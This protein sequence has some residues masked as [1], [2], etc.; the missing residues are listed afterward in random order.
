M[1]KAQPQIKGKLIKK[2]WHSIVAGKDF[3]SAD[4]GETL[5]ADPSSMMHRQLTVNLANLTGDIRQQGISLQFKVSEIRDGKGI[6]GVTGYEASASQLHRLVRRGVERLDDSIECM[7]SDGVTIKIKPF[8]VTKSAVSKS[9][10]R[11]M[12]AR[13]REALRAESAKTT[14]SDF[15]QSVISHKLQSLLKDATRK[16]Y[17]LRA[18]EIRK[19]VIIGG[20]KQTEVK[21][22][23]KAAEKAKPSEPAD[24]L[25]ADEKAAL[26][27]DAAEEEKPAKRAEQPAPKAEKE[28]AAEDKKS[29]EDAQ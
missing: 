19:L 21:K 10:L 24:E 8:A 7:T 12:R 23:R 14:Y 20:E 6:A 16:I 1:A 2:Q 17:P 29:S 18:I 15:M 28:S 5:A 26:A 4:L 22:Q 27:T 13:L 3:N 9:K 25:K 11:L